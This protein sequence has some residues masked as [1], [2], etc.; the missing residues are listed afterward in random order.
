MVRF[1]NKYMLS[2]Q[3]AVVVGALTYADNAHAAGSD[4]N[5]STISN[6]ITESIEELP[7][8]VTT[9]SYLM[10][11]LLGVLGVMKVKDHVENPGNTPLKDGAVRLAAGG[12]LFALPIVFESMMNTIGTTNSFVEPA[13]LSKATVTLR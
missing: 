1:M 3:A 12:A 13:R 7:A 11:L 4:A 8:L 10:G 2:F 6:N 5:F 9:L